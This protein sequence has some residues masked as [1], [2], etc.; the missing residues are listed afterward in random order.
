MGIR[1]VDLGRE[2]WHSTQVKGEHGWAE[3]VR[4]SDGNSEVP[5]LLASRRFVLP[6]EGPIDSLDIERSLDK[7]IMSPDMSLCRYDLDPLI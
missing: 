3:G 7:W 2:G 6:R 1:S 5:L 4:V